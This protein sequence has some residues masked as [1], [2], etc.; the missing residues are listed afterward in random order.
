MPPS[1]KMSNLFDQIDPSASGAINQNQFQQAFQSMNPAPSFQ[2]A[3]VD[4]V[5]SQ[6][7]P[8]GTGSVSKQDFVSNM[9][10]M[11][12]QFNG[13]GPALSSSSGAQELAQNTGALDALGSNRP[14]LNAFA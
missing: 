7:D 12:K 9:A 11:I 1:K 13:G 6:L 2:A 5:W 14:T 8:N 3:G 10:A 4:A